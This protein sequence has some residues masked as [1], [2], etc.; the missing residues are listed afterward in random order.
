VVNPSGAL[1]FAPLVVRG[2]GRELTGRIEPARGELAL[3]KELE[4]DALAVPVM[5]QHGV[6]GTLLLADAPE[7]FT[8]VRQVRDRRISRAEDADDALADGRAV[9]RLLGARFLHYSDGLLG[10]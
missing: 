9:A 3:E 6:D 2:G 8:R 10:V 7:A 1:Q 4:L 5:A